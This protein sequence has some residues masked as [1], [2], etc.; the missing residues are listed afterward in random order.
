MTSKRET[1]RHALR[2]LL[3]AALAS[4]GL[5]P[6]DQFKLAHY[7]LNPGLRAHLYDPDI[8]ALEDYLIDHS[9]LPGKRANLEMIAALADEVGALCRDPHTSLASSYVAQEWLLWQL[10]Y[11]YPPAIYGA[12]PDSPLQMPQLAGLVAL[13]EWAAAFHHIESG[14]STLLDHARSPLWRVREAVAFGLQ[15]LLQHTWTST[16]RRVQRLALDA[17]AWQWRALVAGYAEPALLGDA[18]HAQTALDLHYAALA[19]LRQLPRD[20]RRSDGVKVLHQALCYSIGVVVA[21]LPD[22]GF[23]QMRAWAAWHDPDIDRALRANLKHK[24]LAAWP[25]H[26]SNLTRQLE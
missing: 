19:F 21:A 2:P 18:A 4:E 1:H 14:T 23:A 25:D 20:A 3:L 22:A 13:G 8:A 10:I 16:V 12:D 26:V 7:S 6:P 24:R 17:D 9:N 15:R 11:R 5:L